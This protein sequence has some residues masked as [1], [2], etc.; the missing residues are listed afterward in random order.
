VP[1]AFDLHHY[2]FPSLCIH[3]SYGRRAVVATSHPDARL[4]LS[5]RNDQTSET[6]FL[7]ADFGKLHDLI[8]SVL[9]E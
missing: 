4:L 3:E 8:V 6:I 1:S 5:I 9:A 2:A 7:I